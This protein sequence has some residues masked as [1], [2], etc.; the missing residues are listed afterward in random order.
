M[1][2]EDHKKVEQRFHEEILSQQRVLCEQ[3]ELLGKIEQ[4]YDK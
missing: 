4:E 3:K 2:Q 1:M